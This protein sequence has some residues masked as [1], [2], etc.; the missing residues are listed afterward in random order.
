MFEKH[1][2]V[3]YTH[4]EVTKVTENIIITTSQT[5]S[6]VF[7]RALDQIKSVTDVCSVTTKTYPEFYLPD[8]FN[9]YEIL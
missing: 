4:I 9:F 6:F 8:F 3:V 1:K 7:V 2:T 5:S